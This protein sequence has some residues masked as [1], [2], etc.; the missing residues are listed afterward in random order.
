MFITTF[1][2]FIFLLTVFEKI[3]LTVIALW[4]ILFVMICWWRRT[5]THVF[6]KILL[7][8]LAFII[9]LWSYLWKEYMVGGE[10]LKNIPFMWTWIIQDTYTEWKYIFADHKFTYVLQSKKT[11]EIGDEIFLLGRTSSWVFS[12]SASDQWFLAFNYPKRLK[13]K[14][15]KWVIYETNSSVVSNGGKCFARQ[16][17]AMANEE[18][19]LSWASNNSWKIWQFSDE[20]RWQCTKSSVWRIKQTKKI[21]QQ[22]IMSTYGKNKITGLILWMLIGDRS[23]IPK[24]DYQWFINSW[25]VHI[26]AVS[27]GNIVMIVVFLWAILFFLPFYIRSGVILLTIIFYWLLCGMDSSVLR[28][29]ITWWLS[30]L[31]LFRGREVPIWR[32]LAIAFVGMLLINPY[33]LVY[34]VWFIMSFCAVIWIIYIGKIWQRPKEEWEKVAVSIIKSKSKY[35]LLST[36]YWM[37][38]RKNYLQPSIGATLWI[39]PII[40]FF[41]G[42]L[43]LLSIASNLFILPMLPFVMI[44]GFLS[45]FVYQLVWWHRILWIEK[46]LVTYIYKVS[47]YSS[48]FGLFLSAEDWAKRSLL[49]LFL[50]GFI[51]RRTKNE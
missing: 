48:S 41:M 24:D 36:K 28:A 20:A 17:S 9:G 31:A 18:S 14:W 25:L 2:I 43:N 11:Y 38:V 35:L 8:V 49:I 15:W 34:D 1:A 42:K 3:Y 46:I 33:Y 23:Q 12:G 37:Y 39:F 26:I 21:L 47:E 27:G 45:I 44:Y 29:V 5:H 22:K 32:L 10:P 16:T 4:I 7:V 50:V 51:M 6:K 30:L 19:S 13:M 40:I